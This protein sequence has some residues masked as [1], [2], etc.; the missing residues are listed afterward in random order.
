MNVLFEQ[1]VQ[2][3]VLQNPKFLKKRHT[4]TK[5]HYKHSDSY[6]SNMHY[7]CVQYRTQS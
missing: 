6:L 4:S 3:E 1:I 5:K 7:K 2:Y